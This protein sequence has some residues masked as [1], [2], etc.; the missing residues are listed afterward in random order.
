MMVHTPAGV[1]DVSMVTTESAPHVAPAWQ[2]YQATTSYTHLM[3]YLNPRK[4]NVITPRCLAVRPSKPSSLSQGIQ[5][6]SHSTA[7]HCKRFPDDQNQ[8]GTV[9]L[10]VK[11]CN[12]LLLLCSFAPCL[13]RVCRSLRHYTTCSMLHTLGSRCPTVL[14]GTSPIQPALPVL[15]HSLPVAGRCQT[16]VLAARN[17]HSTTSNAS[18]QGPPTRKEPLEVVSRI[19]ACVEMN[20]RNVVSRASSGHLV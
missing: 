11:P 19:A 13:C 15:Q 4:Y 17:P 2:H 7:V 5:V 20:V 18:R 12:R 1:S 8:V 10:C 14:S 3:T 6:P 9:H 16:L